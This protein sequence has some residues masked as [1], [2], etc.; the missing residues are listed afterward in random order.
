VANEP[1]ASCDYRG[2][3]SMDG[4]IGRWTSW[5]RWRKKYG[6]IMMVDDAHDLGACWT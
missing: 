5:R 4:D 3:F 2:V 6:A 1:G